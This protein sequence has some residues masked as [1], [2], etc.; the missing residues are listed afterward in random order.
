M[1]D[2]AT[3][4]LSMI[5]KNEEQFLEGCLLSVQGIVDEI[6]VVDTGS[7]DRTMEIAQRFGAKIISFPWVNDFSAARNESLRHATCDWILYLDADERITRDQAQRIKSLVQAGDVSAYSVLIGGDHVLPGGVVRQQNAYPRLFRRHPS[8]K[9]EGVVHEQITPSILRLGKKI[10]PS[11]IVIEH[12][13]YGQSLELINEKCQRNIALLHEQLKR[14]P[15]D[16]YARF[17]LGNTFSVL[18]EYESARKELEPL[19]RGQQLAKSVRVSVL[20]ILA[21]MDIRQNLFESAIE[22]SLQSLKLAPSQVMARWFLAVAYMNSNKHNEA[23]NFLHEILTL[24]KESHKRE[25]ET[26]AHDVTIEEPKIGLQL[27]TCYEQLTR[28]DEAFACYIQAL[29]QD[30]DNSTCKEGLN[31]VVNSLKDYK[32]AIQQAEANNIYFY[33]LYK[34]GVD[35]AVQAGQFSDALTY[36]ETVVD[37]N[38]MEVPESVKGRLKELRTMLSL[39]HQSLQ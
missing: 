18:G 31:R 36:I 10:I 27:G 33:P 38:S 34:R 19:L 22:K 12:L 25:A 5:V 4:S 14:N 24:Q 13:G 16:G 7:T 26:I 17:Q 23:V 35:K 37:S 1:S 15:N 20:N 8:I 6:V 2:M 30:P 3:I 21:E 9:F 32:L 28:Y 11:D 29:G 39:Q